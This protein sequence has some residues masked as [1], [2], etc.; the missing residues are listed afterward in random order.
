M[1]SRANDGTIK[2]FL[3]N[4]SCKKG[5]PPSNAYFHEDLKRCS[6]SRLNCRD[7][8]LTVKVI[9]ILACFALCVNAYRQKQRKDE[10]LRKTS[11]TIQRQKPGSRWQEGDCNVLGWD[12]AEEGMKVGAVSMERRADAQSQSFLYQNNIIWED[13]DLWTVMSLKRNPS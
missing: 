13:K 8:I 3:F 5:Q 2:Y 1:I 11:K 10:G 9:R 4:D 6:D 7:L 12:V